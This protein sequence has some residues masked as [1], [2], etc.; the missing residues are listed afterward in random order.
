MNTPH[1]TG[2]ALPEREKNV[3]VIRDI[4]RED[5]DE[6]KEEMK[7]FSKR[8]LQH[9][10]TEEQI[11]NMEIRKPADRQLTVYVRQGRMAI[12]KMASDAEQ[13]SPE[14]ATNL[15]SQLQQAERSL[16]N[17]GD[18]NTPTKSCIGTAEGEKQKCLQDCKGSGKKFCGCYFNSFLAKANCFIPGKD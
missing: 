16:L 11:A 14:E 7:L 4:S 8:V 2:E 17:L 12:E 6:M 18:N 3:D 10:P 9:L 13:L 5:L 15:Y 1:S